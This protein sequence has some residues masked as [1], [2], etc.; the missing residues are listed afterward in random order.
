MTSLETAPA[1]ATGAAWRKRERTPAAAGPDRRLSAAAVHAT[2]P[3]AGPAREA[4]GSRLVRLTASTGAARSARRTAAREAAG[5]LLHE[6][7][8]PLV[9]VVPAKV[10][11]DRFGLALAADAHHAAGNRSAGKRAPLRR[12]HAGQR[13]PSARCR[14]TRRRRTAAGLARLTRYAGL[15]GLTGRATRTDVVEFVVR[16]GILELFPQAMTLHEQVAPRRERLSS[17]LQHPA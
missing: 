13:K 9:V 6:Q 1:S 14:R 17:R 11:A 7:E 8:R 16:D 4:R 10:Q 15:P 12:S 2:T 5:L 3:A